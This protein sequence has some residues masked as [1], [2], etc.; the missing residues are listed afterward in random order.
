MRRGFHCVTSSYSSFN[1]L[2]AGCGVLTMKTSAHLA[3]RSRTCWALVAFR[4]SATPRLF[5][6]ANWKGYGS[7]ER[8]C[9]GIFCPILHS[10]PPGGSILMTS[11]PKSERIV[12]A[13]GPAMM[14]ARSS[15]F[16]PEHMFSSGMSFLLSSSDREFQNKARSRPALASLELWSAL[17][18]EG[19][20]SFL[21][22]FGPGANREQRSFQEEAPREARV[23]SFVYRLDGV[24][25]A[26]GCVGNDLVEESFN[27][28]DQVGA[29]D[30]FVHQ[31]DSIG[32]LRVDDSAGQNEL[33]C[34]AFPDQPRKTLRSAIA[35]HHSDLHFGLTEPRSFSG[36]SNRAGHRQFTATTERKT[37][38]S[39]DDR[40]A[41][42]FNEV[43]KRL[44]GPRFLFRRERSIVG[45]FADVRAGR[46]RFVP[47][48]RENDPTH[49]GIVAGVFERGSQ[50]ENSFCVQSVQYFGSI[51]GHIGNRALLLIQNVLKFQSRS[52][53][54]HDSL[55]V[56][57]KTDRA[58]LETRR[59]FRVRDSR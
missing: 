7:S 29:R 10:S 59:Q 2:R 37:I 9:G 30:D 6:F 11:A 24:L 54:T 28:R 3:N 5:R 33:Q 14:L 38:H 49:L 13:L 23:Q 39:S 52:R 43:S 50:F 21:L 46:K 12:A 55:L 47:R 35:R 53:R 32:F 45:H 27:P 57:G 48:S 22:V 17:R 34:T 31:T 56:I 36:D 25:H 20:C 16:S 51:D 26:D 8:G 4:L 58:R 1:F 19:R 18:K 42:V 41:E 40:L 44:A 15:T